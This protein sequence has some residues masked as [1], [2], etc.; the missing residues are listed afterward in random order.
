MILILSMTGRTG[1]TCYL[2]GKKFEMLRYGPNNDLKN[3]TNYLTPQYEDL[4][5]VKE[6]LRDLG[7][8]MS[9]DAS[10][11]SHV[12]HVCSK[13]KQKAGWIL[14]TF[15][16]RNTQVMKFLWKSLIQGHIDYC[17]QLYLPSKSTEMQQIENLQK[18]YTQ[19]IPELKHLDYWTRLRTLHMYSQQRR[20]E[21]YQIIYAWKI[22]E[23]L[24][25]NCGLTVQSSERRGRELL[26]PQLKGRT[27]V[28]SLRSQSFQVN[29]PQLFNAVPK[30]VRDTTKVSVEE[31]KEK[32]DRFLQKIPD[33]PNVD[34]LTPGACNQWTAAPSNSILD[35]VRRVPSRGI[36]C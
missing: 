19:K 32:L 36:G 35:Q 6:S 11:T 34:G 10:F 4:I 8:I 28:K 22:L 14:R 33:E 15:Q 25:P 30:S 9:D 29:G 1:T 23:G 12:H 3:S 13:V 24:A 20:M 21:R 2:M 18:W 16:S 31:F 7:V 27:A 5:E 17:S 26:V